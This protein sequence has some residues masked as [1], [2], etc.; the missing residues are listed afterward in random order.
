MCYVHVAALVAEYLWRKGELRIQSSR[1]V[2]LLVM[3]CFPLQIITAEHL[4]S[5]PTFLQ[6]Q[7]TDAI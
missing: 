2:R 6:S 4:N 3:V 1:S 7:F 5:I